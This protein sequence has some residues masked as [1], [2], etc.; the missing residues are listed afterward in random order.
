MGY[1]LI[2]PPRH[3]ITITV[4]HI[5]LP[6]C[7]LSSFQHIKIETCRLFRAGVAVMVSLVVKQYRDKT[8]S[9]S[10]KRWRGEVEHMKL[11]S[12]Y[13]L[14]APSSSLCCFLLSN[15]PSTF[16]SCNISHIF[17]FSTDK[18]QAAIFF[19]CGL[20]FSIYM[21]VFKKSTQRKKSDWLHILVINCI[22]KETHHPPIRLKCHQMGPVDESSFSDWVI[23]LVRISRLSVNADQPTL[24]TSLWMCTLSLRPCVSLVFVKN[25]WI[26]AANIHW[27]WKNQENGV[28]LCNKAWHD[29]TQIWQRDSKKNNGNWKRAATVNQRQKITDRGLGYFR[30]QVLAVYSSTEYNVP[31]SLFD[32]FHAL[33]IHTYTLHINSMGV[34]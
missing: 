4:R 29:L 23:N 14:P 31:D 19:L 18:F 5:V 21:F 25:P 10:L 27:C 11:A 2:R 30:R 9:L 1:N 15:L 28:I 33:S 6:A 26:P 34:W 3:L 22:D 17:F 24:C 16:S 12:T 32:L 13:S 7:F 8:C 20:L